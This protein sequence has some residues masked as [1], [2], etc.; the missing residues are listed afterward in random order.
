MPAAIR[1]D[2]SQWYRSIAAVL[3]ASPS[4]VFRCFAQPPAPLKPACPAC[5]GAV[6]AAAAG[7]PP[8]APAAPGAV[9]GSEAGAPD[10]DCPLAGLVRMYGRPDRGWLSKAGHTAVLAVLAGRDAL[11]VGGAGKEAESRYLQDPPLPAVPLRQLPK[12]WPQDQQVLSRRD[13]R[14]TGHALS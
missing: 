9:A 3:R 12:R 14:T 10:A 4:A 8:L 11:L 1:I 5:S 7:E 13:Y 6:P 2:A